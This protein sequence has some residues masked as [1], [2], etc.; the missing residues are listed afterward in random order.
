V[1]GQLLPATWDTYHW[2]S[3]QW[4]FFS[5]SS[6]YAVTDFFLYDFHRKLGNFDRFCSVRVSIFNCPSFGSVFTD[7]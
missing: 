1:P 4:T 3:G 2:K 7:S 5:D 6:G